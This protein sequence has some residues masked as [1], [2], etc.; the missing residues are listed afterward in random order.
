MKRAKKVPVQFL[1]CAIVFCLF[2]AISGCGSMNPNTMLAESSSGV[3]GCPI[4]AITIE[5]YKLGLFATTWTAKCEGKTFYCTVSPSGAPICREAI[6]SKTEAVGSSSV[7][8][9]T[10]KKKKK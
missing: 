2:M 8:A 9:N 10:K 3:I 7:K 5:D 4:E 1:S 6:V